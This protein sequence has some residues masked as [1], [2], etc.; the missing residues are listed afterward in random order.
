MLFAATALV[1]EP[2]G[3]AGLAALAKRKGE[4][5]GKHVATPLTGGNMTGEQIRAWLLE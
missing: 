4:L 3:A 2:A 5:A 1:V